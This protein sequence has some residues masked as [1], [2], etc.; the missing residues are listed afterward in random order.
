VISY[1]L[2]PLLRV[3]DEAAV[4]HSGSPKTKIVLRS[5]NTDYQLCTC[6]TVAIP[7]TGDE[8]ARWKA[9]D[10]VKVACK[11][12]NTFRSGGSNSDTF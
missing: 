5:A 11:L 9:I 12:W 4:N 3:L 1:F 10:P 8:R 7:R 2:Y 6:N